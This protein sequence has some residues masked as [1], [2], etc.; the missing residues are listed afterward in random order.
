MLLCK[1]GLKGGSLRGV[2][3]I[4]PGPPPLALGSAACMPSS[5]HCLLSQCFTVHMHCRHATRLVTMSAAFML[6]ELGAH[7]A[8]RTYNP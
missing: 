1:F 6:H 3:P 7:S 2:L 5:L 4:P 8:G